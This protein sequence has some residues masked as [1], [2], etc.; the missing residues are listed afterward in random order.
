MAS[1]TPVI[2]KYIG[3]TSIDITTNTKVLRNDIIAETFPFDRAVNI[4]EA[5][6]FIPM[7]KNDIENIRRPDN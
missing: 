3:N 7:N 5:N 1:H 4:D 2:S 6:K